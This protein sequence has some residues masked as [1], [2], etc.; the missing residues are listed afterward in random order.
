[1]T[2]KVCFVA[3]LSMDRKLR[4]RLNEVWDMKTRDNNL[5]RDRIESIVRSYID[6]TL[7]SVNVNCSP[8]S[9]LGFAVR[10][11][12]DGVEVVFNSGEGT[13]YSP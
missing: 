2:K 8:P 13:F 3:S 12:E 11:N 6:Y 5:I 4:S 9:N 1:M 7:S 10:L